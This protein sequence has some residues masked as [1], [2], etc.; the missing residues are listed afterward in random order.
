LI[1]MFESVSYES[2]V[3]SDPTY[4]FFLRE[5]KID[6]KNFDWQV[7]VKCQVAKLVLGIYID[8][9]YNYYKREMS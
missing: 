3:Q 2:V 7:H 5:A 4:R 9:L 6:E 1:D 8:K